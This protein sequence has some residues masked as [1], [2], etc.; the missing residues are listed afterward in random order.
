MRQGRNDVCRPRCLRWYQRQCGAKGRRR[1]SNVGAPSSYRPWRSPDQVRWGMRSHK[2]GS[3]ARRALSD[4]GEA[5]DSTS[6]QVLVRAKG[7]PGEEQRRQIAD[8][9]ARVGMAAGDVLTAD[10]RAGLRC[11]SRSSGRGLLPPA[12]RRPGAP[13]WPRSDPGRRPISP[14]AHDPAAPVADDV[15]PAGVAA[16]ALDLEAADRLWALS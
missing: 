9:G 7:E 14:G 5:V 1:E 11:S 3:A 2:L 15:E 16:H 4:V 12:A 6:F 10:G 13:R 8:A